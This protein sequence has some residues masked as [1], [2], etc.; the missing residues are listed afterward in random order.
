MARVELQDGAPD[1]LIVGIVEHMQSSL[2]ELEREI[3]VEHGIEQ[4]IIEHSFALDRKSTRL[5]SS[6][7]P[8]SYAVF[9]LHKKHPPPPP[10][11]TD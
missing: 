1:Q 7:K 9:C 11:P 6:H 10:H 2:T 8:I 5:N 3:Q 4:R